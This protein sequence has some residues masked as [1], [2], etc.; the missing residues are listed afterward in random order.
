MTNFKEIRSKCHCQLSFFFSAK[1]SSN[2]KSVFE[3]ITAS[4]I[5]IKGGLICRMFWV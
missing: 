3:I 4:A 2:F 5:S 1:E